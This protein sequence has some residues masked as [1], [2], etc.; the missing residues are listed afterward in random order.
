MKNM[1]P[2]SVHRPPAAIP[3][4]SP[5]RRVLMR[6]GSLLSLPYFMCGGGDTNVVAKVSG[7]PQPVGHGEHKY[8]TM[9]QCSLS[10]FGGDSGCS[11]PTRSGCCSFQMWCAISLMIPSNLRYI[12][13]SI[14]ASCPPDG[15]FSGHMR[16]SI[17]TNR[18]APWHFRGS[19]FSPGRME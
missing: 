14:H 13:V 19:F 4:A 5:H 7:A 6:F 17:F 3:G 11:L 8:A 10:R 18:T 1:E 16:P 15:Q 12:I 2:S 9:R